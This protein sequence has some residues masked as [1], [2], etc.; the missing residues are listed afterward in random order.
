MYVCI[1][2]MDVFLSLIAYPS[3][4]LLW[5]QVCFNKFSSVQSPA[6]IPLGQ[7]TALPRPLTG[8]RRGTWKQGV[9]TK[10]CNGRG[11]EK[12]GKKVEVGNLSRC[13]LRNSAYADD[14]V[15]SSNECHSFQ[16]PYQTTPS[17]PIISQ[18]KHA[19]WSAERI[20]YVHA[21]PIA[22]HVR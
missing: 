6:P 16:S 5:L 9:D 14:I 1:V 4:Q 2:C 22:K 17:H 18:S 3:I 8:L 11:M 19:I 12:T 20:A 10:E 21:H 7:L 15:I 13:T